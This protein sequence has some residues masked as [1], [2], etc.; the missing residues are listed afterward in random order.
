MDAIVEMD[1]TAN[2]KLDPRRCY[3]PKGRV[4]VYGNGRRKATIPELLL[5]RQFPSSLQSSS[6]SISLDAEQRERAVTGITRASL[7]AGK[8]LN[9]VGPTFPLAEIAAAHEA[10]ER[11]TIGNAFIVKAS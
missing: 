10:V 3:G 8:L 5:P 4:I 11:G 1:L 2:A 9:R 6:R 7:E